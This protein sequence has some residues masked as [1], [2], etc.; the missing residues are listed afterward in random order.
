MYAISWEAE[1]ELVGLETGT[2]NVEAESASI[3]KEKVEEHRKD[4]FE[5]YGLIEFNITEIIAL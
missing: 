4:T 5:G 3:A 1:T 2:D